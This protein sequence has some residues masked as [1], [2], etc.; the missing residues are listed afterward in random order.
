[1]AL[2]K[3]TGTTDKSVDEVFNYLADMT[4]AREWDPSISSVTRLDSGDVAEGSSFRV[5]LGFLGRDLE[6]DYFVRNFDPPHGLVLRAQSALFISEDTVTLST[7]D[8]R[9]LLDYQARLSGKG[10]LAILD[11]LFRLA[12]NHFGKQAGAVLSSG[13]LA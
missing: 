9:T 1:M 10:V 5:T 4:N 8:G 12:I 13:F 11:P 2:F 3:F 6:L 7:R